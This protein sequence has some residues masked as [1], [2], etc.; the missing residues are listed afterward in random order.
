MTDR[1]TLLPQTESSLWKVK[2]PVVRRV[3]SA[4]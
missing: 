3:F 4:P 2:A 1:G